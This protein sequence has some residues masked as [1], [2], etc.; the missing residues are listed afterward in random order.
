MR[1]A[2]KFPA[3][4]MSDKKSQGD[5]GL[6]DAAPHYHGHRDCL[7]GQ[8][9]EA[10]AD[11]NSFWKIPRTDITAWL[12]V[13]QTAPGTYDLP[14]TWVTTATTA[15]DLCSNRRHQNCH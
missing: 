12:R 11:A 8:F 1:V 14:V 9:R 2:F 10:G 15:A 13:I 6:A 7:R 3:V 5:R 4:N